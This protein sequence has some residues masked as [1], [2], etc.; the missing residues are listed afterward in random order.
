V[1]PDDFITVPT[2]LRHVRSRID[3]DDLSV[4]KGRDP[5]KA[6]LDSLQSE[7]RRSDLTGVSLYLMQG[8]KPEKIP[9]K[10]TEQLILGGGWDEAGR[11]RGLQKYEGCRLLIK[12]VELGCW[13]GDTPGDEF[14]FPPPENEKA[15]GEV[16]TRRTEKVPPL[17]PLQPI[18]PPGYYTV[19]EVLQVLAHSDAFTSVYGGGPEEEWLSAALQDGFVQVYMRTGEEIYRVPHEDVNWLAQ[20]W[21]TWFARGVVPEALGRYGRKRFLISKIDF[22][23]WLDWLLEDEAGASIQKSGAP[24]RPSSMWIVM[25]EF[26]RR[27]ADKRCGS[28]RMA[29]AHT[30]AAWLKEAHPDALPVTAKSI[31]NKLPSDFQ[32]YKAPKQ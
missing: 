19:P 16:E 31:F 30:L 13:L 21:G 5:D 24:G 11:A 1:I 12:R 3:E 9:F 10:D 22:D 29:E 7:L 27:R 17:Q 18:V 23:R 32:P 20:D 4:L 14:W 2:A 26:E 25:A 28:S 8:G 15:G 6:A